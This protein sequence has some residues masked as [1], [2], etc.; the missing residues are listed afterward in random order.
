MKTQI[1]IPP[2]EATA[3]RHASVALTR[4][5]RRL[6]KKAFMHA[7][8]SVSWL[9]PGLHE[10]GYEAGGSGWPKALKPLATEAFRRRGAGAITDNELYPYQA[11]KARIIRER[12]LTSLNA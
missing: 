3:E 5:P 10:D 9:H 7:W 8:F 12:K 11:A 2:S 1:Y 6:P 4:L